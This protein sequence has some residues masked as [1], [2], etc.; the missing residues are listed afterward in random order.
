MLCC[1]AREQSVN[2][3]RQA[4]FKDT[5]L[6]ASKIGS[7][8]SSGNSRLFVP[9]VFVPVEEF[10]KD[11]GSCVVVVFMNLTN[12]AGSTIGARFVN[13]ESCKDHSL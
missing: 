3:K 2:N 9:I 5:R 10:V 7:M 12:T 1:K 13:E 6:D 8:S 11:C 4:F